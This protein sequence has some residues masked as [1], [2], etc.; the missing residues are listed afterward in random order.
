MIPGRRPKSG[1]H[2]FHFWDQSVDTV[3]LTFWINVSR[4]A[5]NVLF[6]LW[7]ATW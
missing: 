4:T 6:Y 3:K 7:H 2:A 1:M 5:I